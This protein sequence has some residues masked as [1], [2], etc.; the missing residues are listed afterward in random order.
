[1]NFKDM[2]DALRRVKKTH[3]P[4]AYN[5]MLNR[6]GEAAKHDAKEN[7]I[8]LTS[9]FPG[10]TLPQTGD[11]FGAWDPLSDFTLAKKGESD[12]GKGGDPH[13][14]LYDTGEMY[15]SIEYSIQGSQSVT[16]GS[17]S[18][19]AVDTELG[20]PDNRPPA[21]PFLGPAIIRTCMTQRQMMA[22]AIADAL[23]KGA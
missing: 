21:R 10:V 18:D 15:N 19:H 16:L 23:A 7:L 22:K 6:F 5:Q 20:S 8:G 3:L 14:M 11:S 9:P 1:M 2:A 17:D 12:G 4:A 13:T